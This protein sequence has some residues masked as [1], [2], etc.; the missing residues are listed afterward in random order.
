[1]VAQGQCGD[2]RHRALSGGQSRQ[3][4]WAA[5]GSCSSGW[6]WGAVHSQLGYGMGGGVLVGDEVVLVPAG[7]LLG[8]GGVGGIALF[9]G[10]SLVDFGQCAA[11]VGEVVGA[12]WRGGHSHRVVGATGGFGGGDVADVGWR[13]LEVD[14]YNDAYMFYLAETSIPTVMQRDSTFGLQLLQLT[15]ALRTRL[16]RCEQPA[17]RTACEKILSMLENDTSSAGGR[18]SCE[19]TW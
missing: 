1:M 7:Y 6:S 12:F 18:G 3:R 8:A 14:Q 17:A 16:E 4:C 10:S 5:A 11:G 9:V 13:C 15:S 19:Y 2:R